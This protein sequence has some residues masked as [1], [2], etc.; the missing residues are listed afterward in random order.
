VA[1]KQAAVRSKLECAKGQFSPD[2]LRLHE[3]FLE[4]GN[5]QA[6]TS[7]SDLRSIYKLLWDGLRW[8]EETETSEIDTSL[9]S[10]TDA[11]SSFFG[12]IQA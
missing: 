10:S 6:Y 4:D 5:E 7:E 12:Q 8:D 3:K 9:A 1:L 11:E 2:S